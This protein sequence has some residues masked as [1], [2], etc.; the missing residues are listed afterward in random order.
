MNRQVLCW[1]QKLK[2]VVGIFL[3]FSIPLTSSPFCNTRKIWCGVACLPGFVGYRTKWLS[4]SFTT[5]SLKLEGHLGKCV[6]L[7]LRSFDGEREADSEFLCARVLMYLLLLSNQLGKGSRK[8][9]NYDAISGLNFM[10]TSAISNSLLLLL[11][12]G[13]FL[14]SFFPFLLMAA[15]SGSPPMHWLWHLNASVSWFNSPKWQETIFCWIYFI[16]F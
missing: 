8:G 10:A 2:C 7:M 15:L 4:S 11:K 13:V 1:S 6:C 3:T 16:P 5:L 14:S 12:E 9:K